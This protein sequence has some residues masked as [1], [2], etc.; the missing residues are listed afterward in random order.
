MIVAATHA[1]A[2]RTPVRCFKV[3]RV[4]QIKFTDFARLGAAGGTVTMFGPTPDEAVRDLLRR[5]NLPAAEIAPRALQAGDVVILRRMPDDAPP[6]YGPGKT[7]PIAFVEGLA[8]HE[9]T[10]ALAYAAPRIAA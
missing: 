5:L 2:V 9:I 8:Q 6:E 1:N 4:V 10:E 3:G 7:M